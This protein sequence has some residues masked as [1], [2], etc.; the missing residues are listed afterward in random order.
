M[1]RTVDIS[2]E[3]SDGTDF[4]PLKVRVIL[5][6][7]VVF[8]IFLLNERLDVLVRTPQIPIILTVIH[9]S[10]QMADRWVPTLR[11]RIIIIVRRA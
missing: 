6:V 9:V 3:E 2:N 8:D 7:V 1:N 11:V 4:T 5:P 10:G